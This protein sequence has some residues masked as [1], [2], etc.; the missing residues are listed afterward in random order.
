MRRFRTLGCVAEAPRRGAAAVIFDA[1]GRVLLVKENYD[2]RRWSLP[3]GAVE[4]GESEEEAVIREAAEETGVVVRI[5]HLIGSYD[6][7]NG[8]S[9]QRIFARSPRATPRF[10]TRARSRLC[11]GGQPLG[12]RGRVP[13]SCTTRCRTRSQA[14]VTSG[15]SDFLA[16]ADRPL[17][18][19]SGTLAQAR[20]SSPRAGS[21]HRV[22]DT[23]SRVR[24]L[25]RTA[26]PG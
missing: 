24:R 20:E 5:H 9:R 6:L 12:F 15:A 16:S 22:V 10:P 11:S 7:D 2:R 13:T 3:G 21:L 17:R 18:G 25:A 14:A 23:S 1:D 8:F 4:A 19:H 26:S